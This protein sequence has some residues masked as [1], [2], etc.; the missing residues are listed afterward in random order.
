MIILCY[1]PMT[2]LSCSSSDSM[3]EDESYT[4][5][6]EAR[7]SSSG[8][9]KGKPAPKKTTKRKAA[10]KVIAKGKK[11]KKNSRKVVRTDISK[12]ISEP[13]IRDYECHIAHW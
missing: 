6:S 5:R 12:T 11:V 1:S 8:S 9:K 13:T 3:S 10:A 2:K 7:A 4:P